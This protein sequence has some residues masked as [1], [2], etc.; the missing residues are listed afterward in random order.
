MDS[1][2]KDQPPSGLPA[3]LGAYVIW[4]FLPLYMKSRGLRLGEAAIIL[5]LTPIFSVAGT[6]LAGKVALKAT[7]VK[8]SEGSS[9][10]PGVAV[11]ACSPAGSTP[12]T[13]LSFMCLYRLTWPTATASC[14]VHD[15][16]V[17]CC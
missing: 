10:L 17:L 13:A 14:S 1:K 12:I 2:I 4:G 5:S 8:V 16:S 11:S 9:A 15:T 6:C 7:K 3:A